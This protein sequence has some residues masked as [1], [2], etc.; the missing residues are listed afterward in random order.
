MERTDLSIVY[1]RRGFNCCQCVAAVFGD[2]TGLDEQ[3]CLD[4]TAGFGGGCGTGELCGAVAGG[5]IVLGLLT[6]VDMEDPVA[7]KKRTVA[8]G[9]ELQK[10]FRERY[11][12]LRCA[13]LLV[14]QVKTNEMSPAAVRMG[15]TKHCDIM[16][17]SVV[18]IVEEMLAE[19]A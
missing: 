16:I 5:I 2:L 14:N 9:K 19:Q 10:R 3:K 6:P 7:S 18:E 4:L 15:L 8:L 17:V 12:E 13:D 11:G 1:H